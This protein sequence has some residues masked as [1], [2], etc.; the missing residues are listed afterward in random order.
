MPVVPDIFG[1]V[2]KQAVAFIQ[3]IFLAFKMMVKCAYGYISLRT[4]ILYGYIFIRLPRK[5]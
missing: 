3:N 5:Q 1:L 4:D 2:V